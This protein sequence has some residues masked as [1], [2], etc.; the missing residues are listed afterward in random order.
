MKGDSHAKESPPP[1][2]KSSAFAMFVVLGMV[3]TAAGFV[4]YT[5]RTGAMLKQVERVATQQEKRR[6]PRKAGP[7]TKEEWDKIR[8]RLDKDE[9]I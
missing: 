2:P 4:M 8:P 9:L 3:G 1:Q 6:S 5:K 7:Y